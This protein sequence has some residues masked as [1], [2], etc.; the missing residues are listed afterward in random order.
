MP[1]FHLPRKS[2]AVF[3]VPS[4]PAKGST[5][6]AGF[7]TESCFLQ[8]STADAFDGSQ[9]LMCLELLSEKTALLAENVI[10]S[11]INSLMFLS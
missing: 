11:Q 2:A 4:I 5:V 8:G 1:S 10:Y 7:V 3:K 6:D 9:V